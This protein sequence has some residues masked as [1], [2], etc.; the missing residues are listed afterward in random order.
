MT[1]ST[2]HSAGDLLGYGL[3]GPPAGVAER[4]RIR[5]GAMNAGVPTVDD[6]AG[7]HGGQALGDTR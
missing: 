3:P 1:P 7:V 2:I 5:S 6:A 4:P